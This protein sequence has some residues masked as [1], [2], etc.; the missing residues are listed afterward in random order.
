MASL[1]SSPMDLL[2]LIGKFAYGLNGANAAP[3][4]NAPGLPGGIPNIPMSGYGDEKAINAPPAM[5][6]PTQAPPDLQPPQPIQDAAPVPS[7]PPMG[8][9]YTEPAPI[10]T[11][12]TP[13]A[14]QPP[15]AAPAAPP[16]APQRS[17][18]SFMSNLGA[19][20][21]GLGKGNGAILP[22]LGGGIQGVEGQN[23][24]HAFLAQKG[25]SP[26]MIAAI[27][28]NP[29][30]A[31][32]A[33]P[34]LFD[35]NTKIVNDQLINM[36]TGNVVADFRDTSKKG[37]DMKKVTLRNGDEISTYWDGKDWRTPDGKKLTEIAGSDDG[38][39]GLMSREMR[40][41]LTKA[42]SAAKI[43]LPEAM[44]M[45]DDQLRL[46]NEVGASPHLTNAIG[47]INS[48]LPTLNPNTADVEAKIAQLQGGA[49]LQ[50]F[51][52]MKGA[53]AISNAEG[54]KAEAAINRLGN[55][56]QSDAGY[57][58]ALRDA[59]TELIKIREII[60]RK[61]A[62]NFDPINGAGATQ[63]KL[64]QGVTPDAALSQAKAAIAAGKD[65]QAV[66]QRLQSMG[67]DPASAGL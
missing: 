9:P 50:A 20:L 51:Q 17:A 23:A 7:R 47:P 4:N 12:S 11:G 35:S 67:I 46:I 28:A 3:A 55:L 33:L 45:I 34:S 2:S 8:V 64:P 63:G 39:P 5:S 44:R 49:F 40:K 43:A 29:M 32:A 14:P 19:F 57:A 53:G 48:K 62:G 21:S 30:V 60:Q 15:P 66:R 36:R 16:A 41:D 52:A 27:T 31:Q 42:A 25:A 56:K 59:R 54:A 10:T 26:E 18:P 65:P 6:Y 58:E 1:E 37:P 61:A 38:T 24:T 13:A 22:A